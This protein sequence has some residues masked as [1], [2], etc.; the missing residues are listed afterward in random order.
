[1]DGFFKLPSLEGA[2]YRKNAAEMNRLLPPGTI[3]KDE[4]RDVMDAQIVETVNKAGSR[5]TA[6][7]TSEFKAEEKRCAKVMLSLRCTL[8]SLCL[9]LRVK[10]CASHKESGRDVCRAS[11]QGTLDRRGLFGA[12]C[13]H[14]ILL[15]AVFMPASESWRLGTML[16]WKLLL[17]NICPFSLLYDIACRWKDFFARWL[18]AKLGQLSIECRAAALAIFFPLPPFHAYMHSEACRQ[19]H[20]LMNPYFPAYSQPCGEPPESFWSQMNNLARLRYATLEYG[21]ISIENIIASINRRNRARLSTFLKKRVATL[22]R[23]VT[24]E[25]AELADFLEMLPDE[26]VRDALCPAQLQSCANLMLSIVCSSLQQQCPTMLCVQGDGRHAQL[27]KLQ[28]LCVPEQSQD[29]AIALVRCELFHLERGVSSGVL[30][31][32]LVFKAAQSSGGHMRHIGRLERKLAS[33]AAG[34]GEDAPA[35]ADQDAAPFLAVVVTLCYEQVRLSHLFD[36]N[37]CDCWAAS[38]CVCVCSTKC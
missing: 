21:T 33:L 8:Y 30:P 23:R 20:S 34:L 7:C 27:D 1:M 3:M 14:S 35:L 4:E 6:I 12:V 17:A 37:R 10:S 28:E 11:G 19:E 5:C 31:L 38:E 29:T 22:Q 32:E 36:C 24:Q 25:E 26:E 13:D 9:C 18:A 16:I 2:G 15:L